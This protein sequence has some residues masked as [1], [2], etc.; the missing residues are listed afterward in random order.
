MERCA[1]SAPAR[2]ALGFLAAV[3]AVLTFHQG[4]V[5]LLYLLGLLPRAPY[6]LG[7]AGPLGV[8]VL[9]NLCFWGGLYGAAYGLLLPR[10]PRA[11]PVLLLGLGLGL[12]AAL[13]G[14]FVVAPL[15]GLPVAGGWAPM[16]ML[17]SVLING[18]WGIGTALILEA[19]LAWRGRPARA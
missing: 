11:V 8:P 9:V 17:R 7:P 4:M 6:Q 15:K 18:A 10:L 1:M 16:A 3:L 13:V 12:C 5:G 14:W 19:I 2:A